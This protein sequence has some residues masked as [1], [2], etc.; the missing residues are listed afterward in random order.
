MKDFSKKV[1]GKGELMIYGIRPVMEVLEAGKEIERIFIHRQ[2]KGEAMQELKKSLLQHG[3]SWQDVPVEKLNRLTRK[4]HQ[5]VIC[6]ISA[7]SYAPVEE[8]IQSVFNRGKIPLILL[9]DRITDVRNF[10]AIARTAEC[11]GVDA[12]VIPDQGSAQVSPD[13]IKTSA[14]ALNI[15]PVCRV[16][17]LRN[18]VSYLKESGLKI[19]AATEKGNR[20]TFYADYTS[21]TAIILG[22]EE[23]GVSNDLLQLADEKIRIPLMGNIDSLNV[24]VACGMILHEVMRQRTN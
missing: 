14:G 24:S 16:R 4:N 17:N 19:F 20:L 7:I 8:I 12:I 3:I 22:S 6:F 11:T 5:D 18:T 15:I 9:L 13:A 21:P 2:A 23:S 10:G 1:G